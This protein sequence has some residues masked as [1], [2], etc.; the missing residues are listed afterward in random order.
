MAVLVKLWYD[1]NIGFNGNG[2]YEDLIYVSGQEYRWLSWNEYKRIK[3]INPLRAVV[4]SSYDN[5]ITTVELNIERITNMELIDIIKKIGVK[6]FN[7][8]EITVDGYDK[9]DDKQDDEQDRE[10][11]YDVST[12]VIEEF[13]TPKEPHNNLDLVTTII[14]YSCQFIPIIIKNSGNFLNIEKL[15]LK[16]F[17]C[18]MDINTDFLYLFPKLKSLCMGI[19]IERGSQ[20]LPELDEIISSSPAPYYKFWNA[21]DIEKRVSLKSLTW[22][23]HYEDKIDI[24]KILSL[25]V[26]NDTFFDEY[27][28]NSNAQHY[29]YEFGRDNIKKISLLARKK[30]HILSVT[31]GNDVIYR[32][33]IPDDDEPNG[34]SD[35]EYSDQ[36]YSDQEYSD[37]D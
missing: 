3:N 18:P 25:I 1:D 26:Y 20:P 17:R 32:K 4:G 13:K 23:S 36:E 11:N 15:Y 22:D 9:Q 37:S 5:D 35:Q 21:E 6:P 29:H 28:F 27:H 16:G 30:E 8:K 31:V 12:F 19:K 34:E 2:S 7:S 24:C 14:A 10:N 33:Y